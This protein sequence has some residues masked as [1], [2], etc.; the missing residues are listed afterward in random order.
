MVL[1]ESCQLPTHGVRA[2]APPR[3]PRS[4]PVL[5]RGLGDEREKN[6][7]RHEPHFLRLGRQ[8]LKER[9]LEPKGAEGDHHF[10]IGAPASERAV[11]STNTTLY[12]YVGG[13]RD[14]DLLT[15]VRRIHTVH[16]GVSRFRDE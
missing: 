6:P 7:S 3:T 13:D 14:C 15:A 4:A 8:C 16:T 2:A 1:D 10:W 5:G 12:G 11:S 9:H